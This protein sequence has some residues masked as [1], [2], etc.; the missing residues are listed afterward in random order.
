MP[1]ASGNTEISVVISPV[2]AHPGF[3]VDRARRKDCARCRR[4]ARPIDFG[5]RIPL[6]S[7]VRGGKAELLGGDFT[8]DIADP[9]GG[10]EPQ[11]SVPPVA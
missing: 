5:A 10:K 4:P 1:V 3:P 8:K 6:H 11:C 9:S 7:R 2:T